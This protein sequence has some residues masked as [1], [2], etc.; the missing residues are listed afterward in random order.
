VNRQAYLSLRALGNCTTQSSVS[1]T[2]MT[3]C[4]AGTPLGNYASFDIVELQASVRADF[5][6]RG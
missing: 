3:N 2:T 1:E 6:N 4:I 5:A